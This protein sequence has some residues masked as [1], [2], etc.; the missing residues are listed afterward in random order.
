MITP[1]A[2]DIVFHGLVVV[3]PDNTVF[4][5]LKNAARAVETYV[6]CGALMCASA[7]NCGVRTVLVTNDRARVTA[8][9]RSIGAMDVEVAEMQFHNPLPKGAP[10]RAAHNK[11]ALIAE[12]S[13]GKH[14]EYVGVV[15]L[16]VVFLNAIRLS[17]ALASD[18]IYNYDITNAMSA[19]SEG[20]ALRE[21]RLFV[22]KNAEEPRW[23][24]GEVLFAHHAMLAVL[25][26]ELTRIFPRYLDC[27]ADLYHIGDEFAVSAATNVIIARGARVHD[28]GS[29]SGVARW[30]TL[31]RPFP[32]PRLADIVC[33][34]ILHLPGDKEFLASRAGCEFN[35]EEFLRRYRIYAAARLAARRFYTWLE[36]LRG[37]NRRQYV[38]RI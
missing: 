10:H 33:S 29:D 24:G 6:K 25:S 12:L 37:N 5:N 27:L 23:F 7:R 8:V 17:G 19:E 31:R 13:T 20:R 2:R 4:P 1:C 14:G 35:R 11:L 28:L 9:L 34:S 30:W 21:L 26:R 3:D 36:R 15:D 16:D 32:Q 38:A 22:D 18:T